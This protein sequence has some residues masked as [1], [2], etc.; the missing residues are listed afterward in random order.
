MQREAGDLP[1]SGQLGRPQPPFAR[2]QLPTSLGAPYRQRLEQSQSLNRP[3]QFLQIALG[4]DMPGLVR[5]RKNVVHRQKQHPRAVQHAFFPQQL[6]RYPSYLG[7]I[8]KNS[9]PY[10]GIEKGEA[11]RPEKILF[12]REK[13]DRHSK[14]AK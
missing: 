10:F 8:Y 4:K 7:N 5:I 13:H 9:L 11:G 2:H 14:H 3:G 12:S 6:H 1:Q